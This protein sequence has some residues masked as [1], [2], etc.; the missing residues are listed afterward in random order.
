MLKKL[1]TTDILMLLS[2]FL[3]LIFAELSWFNGEKEAAIFVGLWVPSIIG[4]A[5]YLKLIMMQ[6]ND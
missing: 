6:K 3:S 5:I 1:T 4:F 2:A